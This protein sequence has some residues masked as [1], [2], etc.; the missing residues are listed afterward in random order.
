LEENSLIDISGDIVNEFYESE[1]NSHSG[2][3]ENIDLEN[4]S[5]IDRINFELKHKVCL[6]NDPI[7]KRLDDFRK[8]T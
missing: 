2:S 3:S 4:M 5:L 8:K 7:R 1:D 6:E